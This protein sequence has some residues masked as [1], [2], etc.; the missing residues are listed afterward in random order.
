[1][2]G[3]RV[4]AP[5]DNKVGCKDEE[6]RGSQGRGKMAK[7]NHLQRV[8]KGVAL[9]LYP[10]SLTHVGGTPS[11]GPLPKPEYIST[12]GG[13]LYVPLPLCPCST[14]N[15]LQCVGG[16]EQEKRPGRPWSEAWV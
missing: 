10:L 11:P 16:R 6:A 15:V 12:V 5:K 7:D 13:F 1:M 8:W 2:H 4:L 14:K 3:I 9:Y